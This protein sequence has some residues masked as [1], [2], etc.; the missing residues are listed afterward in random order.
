MAKHGL[1]PART[2]LQNSC[3][4]LCFSRD[5]SIKCLALVDISMSMGSLNKAFGSALRV[6]FAFGFAP[7]ILS[8]RSPF[9]L[10]SNGHVRRFF[11]LPF[12]LGSACESLPSAVKTVI[13]DDSFASSAAIARIMTGFL[14]FIEEG[15]PQNPTPFLLPS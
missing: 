5:C 11:L 8:R 15:S 4:E 9:L 10:L 2:V 1:L 7:L 12:T 13:G 6:K 3:T 14:A